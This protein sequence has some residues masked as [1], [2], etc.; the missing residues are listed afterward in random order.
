MFSNRPTP[1]PIAEATLAELAERARLL[2]ED[3]RRRI[4]GVT[5]TPGAGKSTVTAALLAALG[6]RAVIV[7]MDGFH[8]ANAELLRLG[9]RDRKGAPDTFDVD[10]YVALL[11]RLSAQ[12]A[13][14]IYAPVFDRALEESIGSAVAVSAEVPLVITEGNYLL[15]D[16]HGWDGVRPL[17]DEVWYLDIDADE[18]RRRLVARRLGH[19]HPADEATA[20]VRDVDEPNARVVETARDRADLV[21]R[22]VPDHTVP[23]EGDSA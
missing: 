10:G 11:S 22:V 17:L 9:R 19:G 15:H 6:D 3:G 23:S 7:G 14:T 12:T 18:R 5:G 20:W 21:V 16:A 8:F 1:P 2:A 4:L 13:G